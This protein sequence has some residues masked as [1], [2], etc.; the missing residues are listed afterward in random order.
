MSIQSHTG[1]EYASHSPFRLSVNLEN[2]ELNSGMELAALRNC[3]LRFHYL[4]QLAYKSFRAGTLGLILLLHNLY[5]CINPL[6]SAGS[7]LIHITVNQIRLLPIVFYYFFKVPWVL[8]TFTASRINLQWTAGKAQRHFNMT[9]P[10]KNWHQC[11]C[12]H[13][14][15]LKES[16][17]FC[18]I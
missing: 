10:W 1:T 11:L 2:E 7:L 13:G 5:T 15:N 16:Y 17:L 9:K 6:T 12:F 4:F 18:I 3:S 8:T 14:S